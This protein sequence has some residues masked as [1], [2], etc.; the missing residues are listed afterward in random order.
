MNSSPPTR[1]AMSTFRILSRMRVGEFLQHLVAHVMAM[2]V[3]HRLEEIDVDGKHR[4]RLAAVD[5][6]LDQMAEM[7]FHVAPVVKAGERIGHRHFD[8]GLHA[9]AQLLGIAARRI[10]VLT[11][12]SSSC[13][14]MGRM[15]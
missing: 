11:R 7:G 1:Q 9:D 4:K 2:G 13:R 14:S 15:R 6:M 5:G 8:G 12:A 10:C 3:V